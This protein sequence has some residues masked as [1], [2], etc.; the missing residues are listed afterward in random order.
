[1]EQMEFQ[2]EW[3]IPTINRLVHL[4]SDQFENLHKSN[5][6][7]NKSITAKMRHQNHRLLANKALIE[8]IRI[9]YRGSQRI[10]TIF[11]LHRGDMQHKCLWHN[12]SLLSM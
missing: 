11:E 1:M 5:R 2:I 3:Q 6:E 12:Q 9:K 7:N 4:K 10:P 8:A